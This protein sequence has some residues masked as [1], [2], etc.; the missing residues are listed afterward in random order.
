VRESFLLTRLLDYLVLVI[1]TFSRSVS[2]AVL[3]SWQCRWSNCRLSN[4][5][6]PPRLRGIR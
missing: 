4:P 5:D 2:L 1:H 6:L 3:L